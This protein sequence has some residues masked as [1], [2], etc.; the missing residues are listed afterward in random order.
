MTGMNRMLNRNRIN[1]A[2]LHEGMRAC[3]AIDTNIHASIVDRR[4]LVLLI[5]RV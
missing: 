1:V 2:V 3:N 5:G 4:V